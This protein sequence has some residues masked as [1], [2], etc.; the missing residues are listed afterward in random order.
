MAGANVDRLNKPLPSLAPLPAATAAKD[1]PVAGASLDTLDKTHRRLHWIE[2][3][4][5]KSAPSPLHETE[6]NIA[7]RCDKRALNGPAQSKELMPFEASQPP[8]TARLPFVPSNSLCHAL[9]P[10]DPQAPEIRGDAHGAMPAEA[11]NVRLAP[12]N[13]VTKISVPMFAGGPAKDRPPPPD[14]LLHS[15]VTKI[16]PLAIGKTLDMPT[17]TIT[18]VAQSNAR[19][20][21][22]AHFT[23]MVNPPTAPVGQPPIGAR[24]SA[25]AEPIA[26][27]RPIGSE[28]ADGRKPLAGPLMPASTTISAS[29]SPKT[30]D[31]MLEVAATQSTKP[32]FPA[33]TEMNGH[34]APAA[35]RIASDDRNLPRNR[36]EQTAFYGAAPPQKPVG[37]PNPLR[38]S[39]AATGEAISTDGPT[40]RLNPLR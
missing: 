39:T 15:N 6:P 16:D 14:A 11:A 21:G 4:K 20:N 9:P 7:P 18:H 31:A 40:G 12:P 26:T 2:P 37:Q 29:S 19:L 25:Y 36:V 5:A 1:E 3:P 13:K 22:E 24:F 32:P 30:T 17:P 33:T 28:V 8:A 23:E 35:A 38:N 34:G 27:A 10:I